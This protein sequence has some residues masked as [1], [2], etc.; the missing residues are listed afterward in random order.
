M[1]MYTKA[2]AKLKINPCLPDDVAYAVWF[3]SSDM[4]E[5]AD[6]KKLPDHDFFKTQRWDYFHLVESKG[7]HI[8]D[9]DIKNYDGEIELF[10]DWIKPYVLNPIG[11]EIGSSLYEEWD[12]DTVYYYA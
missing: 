5:D 2:D 3:L 8:L 6:V 10:F 9:I 4:L 12:A 1:G 7:F 11:S